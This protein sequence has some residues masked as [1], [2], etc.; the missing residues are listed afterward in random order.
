MCR[1]PILDAVGISKNES[2]I[3]RKRT[4]KGDHVSLLSSNTT[5][6]PRRWLIMMKH[7]QIKTTHNTKYVSTLILQYEVCFVRECPT[8]VAKLSITTSELEMTSIPWAIILINQ[9]AA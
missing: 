1:G 8:R 9:T 4:T 2:R 7:N 5:A 3:A 6:M